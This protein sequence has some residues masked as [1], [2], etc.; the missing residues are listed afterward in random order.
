[1][2][3]AVEPKL[4]SK[5][6]LV[7]EDSS[8][9]R[10]IISETLLKHNY[11]IIEAKD[12][13]EALYCLG[14]VRPD[15]ILLDIILPK[16]DGYKICSKIKSDYVL[17]S[18]PVFFLTSKNDFYSKIKGRMAGAS[19]YFTKPFDPENLI[20]AIDKQLKSKCNFRNIIKL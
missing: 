18:I 2:A 13:E 11:D 12:G 14:E 9:T 17:K 1:M 5:K 10:K 8:T 4:K 6:I 15:L 16:I 3:L 20:K 7:V 19:A